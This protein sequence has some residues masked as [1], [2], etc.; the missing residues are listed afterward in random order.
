MKWSIELSEYDIS[1]VPRIA[2]KGQILADFFSKLKSFPKKTPKSLEKEPWLVY[3]DGSS[4]QIGGGVG[5]H[6][7][8]DG[9]VESFYVVQ[10]NFK[11]MNNEAQYKA[12]LIGLVIAKMSRAMVVIIRVDT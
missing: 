11:V 9:D 4:C 3:V 8:V 7:I 2:V 5:I 1:Y 10:L 6:M 12:M